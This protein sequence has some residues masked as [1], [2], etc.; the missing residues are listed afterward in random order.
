MMHPIESHPDFL[1]GIRLFNDGEFW[2]SHEAIERVW[3]PLPP[4]LPERRCLQAV[5]LLAAAFLHRERARTSPDRS[6]KP[7]L[8]CANSARRKLE[9]LPDGLLGLDVAQLRSTID[10]CFA[11][12]ACGRVPDDIPAPPILVLR[13]SHDSTTSPRTCTRRPTK[14]E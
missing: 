4:D 3:K 1:L 12:L 13:P 14:F 2:D 7:A 6:C 5:I 11:P 8:R 9:G 10:R